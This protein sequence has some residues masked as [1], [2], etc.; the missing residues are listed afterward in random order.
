MRKKAFLT[1]LQLMIG[2]ALFAQEKPFD[3]ADYETVT[4]RPDKPAVFRQDVQ[5]PVANDSFRLKGVFTRP[6]KEG[7]HPA[8]LLLPGNASYNLDAAAF[9]ATVLERIAQTFAEEGF[10]VLYFDDRNAAANGSYATLARD[11]A[12]ALKEL[13]SLPQVDPRKTGIVAHNAGAAAGLMIAAQDT[14]LRFFVPMAAQGAGSPATMANFMLAVHADKEPGFRERAAREGEVLMKIAGAG[15]PHYSLLLQLKRA[16]IGFEREFRLE[17]KIP[18]NAETGY[19]LMLIQTY[20][21]PEMIAFATYNPTEYMNRVKCPVLALFGEN[22][23]LIA[24]SAHSSAWKQQIPG[25]TIRSFPGM[26]HYLSNS[27]HKQPSESVLKEIAGWIRDVLK[28]SR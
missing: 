17:K 2:C 5:I 28:T 4:L 13:R 20:S 7:K 1:G 15:Q 21:L 22:D 24:P 25:A 6:G 12:D 23:E 27:G 26:N 9:S 3:P 18:D 8:I 19:A 16:A 14:T 10:A 11:A